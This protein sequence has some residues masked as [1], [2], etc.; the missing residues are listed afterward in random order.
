MLRNHMTKHK[1]PRMFDNIV[2]HHTPAGDTKSIAVTTAAMAMD[3]AQL[4]RSDM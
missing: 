2:I 3:L 4:A 1:N